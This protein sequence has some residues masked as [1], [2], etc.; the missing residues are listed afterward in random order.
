[1]AGD[2]GIGTTLTFSGGYAGVIRTI[3]PDEEELPVLDKTPLNT[4]T[5]RKKMLGAL[6]DAAGFSVVITAAL[7]TMNSAPPPMA[8]TVETITITEPG[9]GTL[10]GG[11]FID[12]RTIAP[13]SETEEHM[14]TEFHVTWTGY[15][16]AAESAAGPVWTN[17]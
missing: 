15:N 12:K 8:G 17:A 14:E 5:T 9:G 1:M 2:T 16:D 4:T 7:G 3:T 6:R 10:V 11:G 13:M